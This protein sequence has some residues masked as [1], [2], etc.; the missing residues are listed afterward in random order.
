[1]GWSTHEGTGRWIRSRTAP[2]PRLS[3]R[4]LRGPTTLEQQ[5]LPLAIV[6]C[7]V[8]LAVVQMILTW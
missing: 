3:A 7:F 4:A 1:M 6:A 2:L 8:A 5:A